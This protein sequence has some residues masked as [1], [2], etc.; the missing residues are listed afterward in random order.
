MMP[1]LF[2]ESRKKQL[3]D[4]LFL[5]RQPVGEQAL[6]LFLAFYDNVEPIVARM[7]DAKLSSVRQ[8]RKKSNGT[9]TRK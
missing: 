7:I 6:E 8:H 9:R 4:V 5:L 3:D 1:A 2:I